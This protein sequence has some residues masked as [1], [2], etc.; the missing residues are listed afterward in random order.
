MRRAGRVGW[1]VTLTC[2][3]LLAGALASWAI[4]SEGD[5]R[6]APMTAE[7]Q[8]DPSPASP[9]AQSGAPADVRGT[10]IT[11]SAYVPYPPPVSVSNLAAAP[12]PYDPTA[13]F[14]TITFELS[15]PA[16]YTVSITGP[17]G[18]TVAI[19][20]ATSGSAGENSVRWDGRNTRNVLVA[21]SWYDC[22]V[23][24]A[25]RYTSGIA[26]CTI[27]VS[28]GASLDFTRTSAAPPSFNPTKQSTRLSATTSRDAY[29]A[30][31]VRAPSGV[32]VRELSERFVPAGKWSVSWD[33]KDSGGRLVAAGTY[34]CTFVGRDSGGYSTS[35]T[36]AVAVVRK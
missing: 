1:L 7:G 12:Q 6:I 5:T 24:A 22:V 25:D 27:A 13:G 2:L 4:S 16:T 19:I 9:S 30:A 21:P 10:S 3:L 20:P 35:T 33:G 29:I 11:V 23:G 36:I 31:I 15:T 8:G 28:H 14:A 26:D 32:V 17:L 34:S 18:E